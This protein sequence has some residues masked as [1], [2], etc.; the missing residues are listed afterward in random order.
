MNAQAQQ[1]QDTVSQFKFAQDHDM[2]RLTLPSKT[3]STSTVPGRQGPR[4]VKPHPA[5]ASEAT[6]VKF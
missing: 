3:T 2:P 1:L 5:V 4:P 6:F